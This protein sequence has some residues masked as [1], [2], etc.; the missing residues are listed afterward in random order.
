MPVV[1]WRTFI[2]SWLVSVV[3]PLVN[4]CQTSSLPWYP[5]SVCLSVCTLEPDSHHVLIASTRMMLISLMRVIW[6]HTPDERHL[7]KGLDQH[8]R[9]WFEAS[10]SVLCVCQKQLETTI[11]SQPTKNAT[12][13]C[14]WSVSRL[15]PRRTTEDKIFVADVLSSFLH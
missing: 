1:S 2:C 10:P 5:V 9:V 8:V 3:V 11:F 13:E 6:V 15:S 12:Q 4:H 7:G 14:C